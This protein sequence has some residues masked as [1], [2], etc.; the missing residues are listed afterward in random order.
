MDFLLLRPLLKVVFCNVHVRMNGFG[1]IHQTNLSYI[2]GNILSTFKRYIFHS[3]FK[4]FV[5]ASLPLLTLLN[6]ITV[7]VKSPEMNCIY[8]VL[9]K[10]FTVIF[11]MFFLHRCSYAVPK[12]HI[13][14]FIHL[15]V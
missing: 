4:F 9:Y 2:V 5:V 6:G 15:Y 1:K 3:D 10:Y 7:S 12:N 8:L 14:E 13:A 11:R